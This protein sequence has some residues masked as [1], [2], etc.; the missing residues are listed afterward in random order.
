MTTLLLIRHGQSEANLSRVFAGNYDAPLTELGLRQA[1]KTAEFITENYK[2]DCVYASD[3]IRAF[4]TGKTVANALNL[5][6]TPN[7][8]LREIRAGK[9]EAIPFDDIVI[10]F[11]E[12]YQKWREDI[13][14]SSCPDGESVK[15]LGER[16]M[17][18]L[19][20][21]AEENDGKTVVIATHATPIRVSQTLIEYGNLAPMQDVPWV[22]NA[23]VTEIIYD[24]GKW[25]LGKVG[26]DSHL[27]D[28]RTNLPNN[29]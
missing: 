9:W 2:V 14:N 5:P 17:A 13:G 21:I 4:E 22:S 28:F 6:I 18:T 25:T 10:K 7:G 27:S 11:P 15:A 12:E 19:T 26:Q 1:E 20:A 16:V 29:V 24:S 3:L 8:G 23:S